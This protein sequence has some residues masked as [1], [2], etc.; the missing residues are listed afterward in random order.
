MSIEQQAK[1]ILEAY[2]QFKEQPASVSGKYHFGETL[3]EHT[4]RC[5]NVMK[6]MCD[7]LD[8]YDNDKDMLVAAAYLHDL[9]KVLITLKD[10]VDFEHWTYFPTTG[11]SRITILMHLHPLMSARILDGHDIDRK[12]EIKRLVSVHMGHWYKD[13]CPQ[14][15]P[16]DLYESLIVLADYLSYQKNLFDYEREMI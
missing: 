8:I 4:E 15:E 9:G 3:A 14:P 7:S 13:S 1:N 10:K 2:P 6:H 12:E 5:A 11:Y 16:G